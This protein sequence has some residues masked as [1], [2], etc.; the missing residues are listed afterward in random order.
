MNFT[1][2][3]TKLEYDELQSHTGEDGFRF[4]TT[5]DGRKMPSITSIL[6]DYKKE[7]I[8]DWIE[9]VGEEEAER[10]RYQASWRGGIVHE[11]L[12]DYING[13]DPSNIMQL[14][15]PVIAHSFI[16][17][18]SA[19]DKDLTEIYG[20]ERPLYSDILNVAGRA[21]LMGK[22]RGK[23]STLDFKTSL[24]SKRKEWITSY[25]MQAAFYALAWEERTGMPIPQLVIVVANDETGMV[26]VFVEESDPWIMKVIKYINEWKEEHDV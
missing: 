2:I 23:A 12:E 17:I 16:Q 19:L 6:K 9:R 15:N 24:K 25:F 21:D 7:V 4:Y 14:Q 3:P 26:Q 11:C 10:I 5:P 22:F 18:K 20:L 1:H 13:V 8:E